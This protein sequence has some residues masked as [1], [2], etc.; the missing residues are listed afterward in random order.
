MELE[1]GEA[2]RKVAFLVGQMVL[3]ISENVLIF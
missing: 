1:W 3:K 2:K